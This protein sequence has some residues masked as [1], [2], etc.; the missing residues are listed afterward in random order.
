[1]VQ[2]LRGIHVEHHLRHTDTTSQHENFASRRKR[3]REG[4]RRS[5]LCETFARTCTNE[6]GQRSSSGNTG[7]TS[8]GVRC[9]LVACT[10]GRVAA[11]KLASIAATCAAAASSYDSGASAVSALR[12][13]FTFFSDTPRCLGTCVGWGLVPG[14]CV[15]ANRVV[16]PSSSDGVQHQRAEDAFMGMS[17]EN[18]YVS[19]GRRLPCERLSF[20]PWEGR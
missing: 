19:F 10:G 5:G 11:S 18:C 1:V 15:S 4:E 14:A 8:T 6:W 7:R 13:S 20:Q 16:W 12:I 2:I 17:R 3:R 9:G